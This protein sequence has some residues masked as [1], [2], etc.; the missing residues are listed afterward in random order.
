MSNNRKLVPVE[1]LVKGMVTIVQ[2]NSLPPIPTTFGSMDEYGN[3]YIPPGNV[4]TNCKF[5]SAVEGYE[6]IEVEIQGL[7]AQVIM[8]N[9]GKTMVNCITGAPG[10]NL[11]RYVVKLP[12]IDSLQSIYFNQPGD[13]VVK[14]ITAYYAEVN[15]TFRKTRH[16]N[17]CTLVPSAGLVD[18]GLEFTKTLIP[19][20]IT[21]VHT[22]VN[23]PAE[24]DPVI[25]E[26]TASVRVKLTPLGAQTGPVEFTWYDQI[27][28]LVYI[29]TSYT[30]FE[31]NLTPENKNSYLT[32]VNSGTVD[33]KLEVTPFTGSY[34]SISTTYG[35]DG[36]SA[37]LAG[38]EISGPPGSGGVI[39]DYYVDSNQWGPDYSEIITPGESFG[40]DDNDGKTPTNAFATLAKAKSVVQDGEVIALR[41]GRLWREGYLDRL[42]HRN[43][44]LCA[45]GDHALPRPVITAFNLFN[46]TSFAYT[47][48][49]AYFTLIVQFSGSDFTGHSM[50]WEGDRQLIKLESEVTFPDPGSYF[51]QSFVSTPPTPTIVY[52]IW[53]YY[54]DGSPSGADPVDQI[55]EVAIRD[56]CIAMNNEC[57]V[58]DIHCMGNVHSGGAI[59]M[60][61]ATLVT[62]C[63]IERFLNCGVSQYSGVFANNVVTLPTINTT[64]NQYQYSVNFACPHGYVYYDQTPVVPGVAD[65]PNSMVVE[66]NVFESGY[67]GHMLDG[68][69]MRGVFVYGPMSNTRVINNSIKNFNYPAYFDNYSNLPTAR[70]IRP[71]LSFVHNFVLNWREGVYLIAPELYFADN[72]FMLD[73]EDHNFHPVQVLNINFF[74]AS[75]T[76]EN[77][78]ILTTN[79]AYA[80]FLMQG[81]AGLILRNNTI[82]A[83]GLTG[84]GPMLRCVDSSSVTVMNN[85][86]SGFNHVL[87]VNPG[88]TFPHINP[89]DWDYNYYIYA[90]SY[91]GMFS[92]GATVYD[93][94]S[95]WRVGTGLDLHTQ[96]DSSGR[97]PRARYG[98]LTPMIVVKPNYEQG[99][100]GGDYDVS[101]YLQP[102]SPTTLAGA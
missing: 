100:R 33:L 57:I 15:A 64:E 43:V 82:H 31:F 86:I 53:P 89:G 90:G 58:R 70:P 5:V 12:R 80:A 3:L 47:P 99:V 21:Y 42:G 44:T 10:Q 35:A 22:T 37:I 73:V 14:R 84:E 63:V 6:Y 4:G 97:I 75:V 94:I 77:N 101:T 96:I 62:G 28:G 38:M 41:R 51:I 92:I 72:L 56:H 7:A 34:E 71:G 102:L 95:S 8:L 27:T 61:Y 30:E 65:A 74:N 9:S 39:A 48:G 32:F 24:I 19:G 26:I 13:F 78:K 66:E 52:K 49:N 1:L 50:L 36:E 88:A 55:Y 79:S 83:S 68:K 54:T 16:D 69:D 25:G 93:N 85:I 81:T 91:D 18:T 17:I 87:N 60:G 40:N 20:A 76:V 2:N 59:M 45:Y 67:P 46:P 98:N 11:G 23:I 29:C